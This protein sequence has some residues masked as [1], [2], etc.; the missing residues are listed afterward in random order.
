MS[1]LSLL[2]A[3][4]SHG[5]ARRTADTRG[6]KFDNFGGF[7]KTYWAACDC[8]RS[9]DDLARLILEVAED[10]ASDGC[11]WVEPAFDV[12][13]YNTL[14][15][16]NE[17]PKP[18]QLF[19]SDAEAWKFALDAAAEAEKATGCG[20][21]FMSAVDRIQSMETAERRVESTLAQ[22][23]GDKHMIPCGLSCIDCKQHAGIVSFGLHGNEEGWPPAP[24][25]DVFKRACAGTC[26]L[27]TPHAGELHPRNGL[28]GSGPT[29]PPVA[30]E[31]SGSQSVKDAIEILGANRI[32]H[33]VLAIDDEETVARL[34]RDKICLDGKAPAPFAS[35]S[36]LK[37][38]LRSLP[39]LEPAAQGLPGRGV[40]P[41]AAADGC[42]GAVLHRL[43]RSAAVRA[44]FAGGVSADPRA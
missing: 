37:Q 34:A 40:P 13:R 43:R 6:I 3:L 10:A 7:V 14:R 1:P 36:R 24:F 42:G 18:P 44:V 23:E 38:L 21:G 32:L 5:C 8:I 30:N 31:V 16:G 9:R 27:C 33:G 20:I 2:A 4:S 19:T 25:A 39:L 22:L 15:A 41:A 17:E 28:P 26:L 12:D 35:A 29:A 11:L